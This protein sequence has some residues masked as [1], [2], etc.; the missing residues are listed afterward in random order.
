ML[1][2]KRFSAVQRLRSAAQNNPPI[3]VGES[4]EAVRV[5]QLAFVSLNFPMPIS[6][7]NYTTLPDGFFGRET[8]QTVKGFQAKYSLQQDGIVGKE[9][10]GKLDQLFSTSVN[11]L[12]RACGN[13]YHRHGPYT[14]PHVIQAA[15][16]SSGSSGGSAQL[17]TS[18]PRFLTQPEIAKAR[19]VFG[20]SLAFPYILVSDALGLEGRAFVTVI[21]ISPIPLGG[22]PMTLVNW[23]PS[24]T[25]GTFF[26]ELT[27]VW[28]SQHHV[29]S[30]AFME[31]ALI[32][33]GTAALFGGSAY[34]FIPGR[35]FARYGAEQIA[36]QVQR[37]KADV[38][39]H[40]R[41]FPPGIPDPTNLPVPRLPFWE[42]PGA[43]G[44]ET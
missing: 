25:D 23:G 35:S 5:L 38:I 6:T 43:P 19:S 10:L 42:T 40:I 16:A 15:F 37:G 21:A 44:V 39:N 33:Q 4:G 30:A 29:E 31:N 32:S 28:Q 34:A 11:N 27:H 14:P 9:T 22:I 41:S 17:P 13:C 7:Q 2:S 3:K 20:N 8:Y 18:P 24:P 26:H 1:S 36:Q 12:P